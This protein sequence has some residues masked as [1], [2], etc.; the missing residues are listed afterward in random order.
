MA[1]MG[2]GCKNCG[3]SAYGKQAIANVKGSHRTKGEGLGH[4]L[5]DIYQDTIMLD[6]SFCSRVK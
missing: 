4:L 2:V 5:L 1:E 3:D 6:V